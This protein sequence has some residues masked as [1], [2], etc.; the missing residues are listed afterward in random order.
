MHCSVDADYGLACL[1]IGEECENLLSN[2]FTR[3]PVPLHAGNH[4]G[5]KQRTQYCTSHGAAVLLQKSFGGHSNNVELCRASFPKSNQ[6]MLPKCDGISTSCSSC[7]P[8][9]WKKVPKTGGIS[10]STE[11]GEKNARAV[12]QQSLK[13][14]ALYAQASASPSIC[15]IYCL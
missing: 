5:A 8:Q 6:L 14:N 1:E 13:L 2:T 10:K 7:I 12:L 4:G 3:T 15:P 9:S 11:P